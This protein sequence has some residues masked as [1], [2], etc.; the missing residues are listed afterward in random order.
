MPTLWLPLK[1]PPSFSGFGQLFRQARPTMKGRVHLS[2]N[3]FAASAV[4]K[5]QSCYWVPQTLHSTKPHCD[6][7][8]SYG[9]GRYWVSVFTGWSSSRTKFQ[10]AFLSRLQGFGG[11]EV[12]LQCCSFSDWFAA[13]CQTK[14]LKKFDPFIRVSF[15]FALPGRILQH[16][17]GP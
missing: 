4:S 12:G 17:L 7:S 8:A 2:V 15:G 6:L 16:S 1:P 5:P 11:S 9:G 10:P 13:L 14:G 3:G